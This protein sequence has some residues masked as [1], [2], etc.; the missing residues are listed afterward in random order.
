MAVAAGDE[1][2]VQ[3][4]S[5]AGHNDSD[6]SQATTY[7]GVNQLDQSAAPGHKRMLS[8]GMKVFERKIL[9]MK[10][11]TIDFVCDRSKVH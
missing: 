1:S 6:M 3:A 2:N 9:A 5:A 7:Q 4:L 8:I 10:N 11:S